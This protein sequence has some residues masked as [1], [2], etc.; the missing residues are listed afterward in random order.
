MKVIT[1]RNVHDALPEALYQLGLCGVETDNRNAG[2]LGKALSFPEPV[3]TVY[4]RPWERVLFWPSRDANP[5]FHLLESVW[6]LA[7]RN[8][9]AFPAAIVSNMA[10]FSDDGETFHGAYG[11]RWRYHFHLDQVA[12]VIRLLKKE[13][14]TRRAVIGIWDASDDLDYQHGKDLPCNLSVA[15]RI[16]PQTGK[17]DMTVYNRSNDIVWG[18]YGANAVHFSMLQ[19]FVAASV[20]VPMGTYTQVSND[21]HAYRSTLG[22]VA[23]IAQEAGD[24][25]LPRSLRGGRNPYTTGLE[26][27]PLMSTDP[28]TWTDDARIFL[29]NLAD[30]SV[31]Y[32]E[33]FFIHVARPMYRA[34]AEWKNGNGVGRFDNAIRELAYCGAADWARAGKEWL[35]RRKRKEIERLKAEDDGVGYE[36]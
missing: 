29:D 30:M 13:P 16:R 31:M 24:S 26:T 4:H 11:Y 27:Y 19:E 23:D 17:L 33:P 21:L 20:G 35:E 5:F 8:D 14:T 22:Q 34:W 25:F 28:A 1:V 10:S 3:T 18:A 2:S 6:M 15:F 32:T 9:V 36:D 12:F 7:G